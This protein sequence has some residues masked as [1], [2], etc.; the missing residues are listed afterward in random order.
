[1]S[2]A[3]VVIYSRGLLATYHTLTYRHPMGLNKGYYNHA[4]GYT[5]H[6]AF[7]P[8]IDLSF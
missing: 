5:T 1:M 7:I 4:I 3:S 2:K 8:L 6:L